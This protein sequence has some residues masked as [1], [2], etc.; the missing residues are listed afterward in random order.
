MPKVCGLIVPKLCPTTHD[1]NIRWLILVES[2][3]NQY[4]NDGS[5][6]WELQSGECHNRLAFGVADSNQAK[7]CWGIRLPLPTVK[8]TKAS[9]FCISVSAWCCQIS[10]ILNTV[11]RRT[12]K[13]IITLIA[14][15]FIWSV[16]QASRDGWGI[17]LPLTL[18]KWHRQAD[19]TERIKAT[20]INSEI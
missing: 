16:S 2:F 20:G 12:L 15:Y 1:R 4:D 13:V 17:R 9:L 19:W 18:K 10:I 6:Y 7:R 3:A 14:C 8:W 5:K 11:F